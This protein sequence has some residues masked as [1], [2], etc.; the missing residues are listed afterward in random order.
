M[1][2]RLCRA[3]CRNRSSSATTTTRTPRS[4]ARSSGR[5][6][7]RPPTTCDSCA[8]NATCCASAST[9]WRRRWRRAASTRAASR[10]TW[11]P[12][13]TPST[14]SRSSCGPSWRSTAKW[15]RASTTCTISSWLKVG[16]RRP[17]RRTDWWARRRRPPK[18]HRR[19]GVPWVY[20]TRCWVIGFLKWRCL[21]RLGF[22]PYWR[23]TI[24][25]YY[26][27]IC[28]IRPSKIR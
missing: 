4:P 25:W 28:S 24:L 2:W 23:S 19:R 18:G 22:R 27:S 11:R 6:S 15:T 8:G 13:S 21:T 20:L 1:R 7:T 5:C 12:C 14:I 17:T 9:K 16:R 10:A 26:K 3:P